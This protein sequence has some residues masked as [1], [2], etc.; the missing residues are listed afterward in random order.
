[1]MTGNGWVR[2]ASRATCAWSRTPLRSS[3]STMPGMATGT[4]LPM[5]SARESAPEA[6]PQNGAGGGAPRTARTCP[7]GSPPLACPFVAELRIELDGAERLEGLEAAAAPDG[8]LQR[9]IDRGSLRSVAA[10]AQRLVEQFLVDREGRG[11]PRPPRR[12]TSSYT[13]FGAPSR[14]AVAHPQPP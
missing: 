7:I 2:S 6:R 14:C 12:H 4:S 3:W 13:L 1:M 8:L 10:D 11:H 5:S 9:L